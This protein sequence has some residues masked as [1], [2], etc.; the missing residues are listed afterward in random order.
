MRERERKREKERRRIVEYLCVGESL[1]LRVAS[2]VEAHEVVTL[3]GDA[4]RLDSYVEVR[5]SERFVGGV[6]ERLSQSS[7]RRL[8]TGTRR[9][10]CDRS[11]GSKHSARG[12]SR[13]R[14]RGNR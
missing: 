8:S 12:Q 11:L 3:V 5:S 14:D 4:W 6:R 9:N 10:D 7:G 2:V 1:C 13:G